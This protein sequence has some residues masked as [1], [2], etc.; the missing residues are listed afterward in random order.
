MNVLADPFKQLVERKLWPI[1]LL[2]V[3]ALVAVPVLLT[4]KADDGGALPT[5]STSVPAGQSPTEPVVS[6]A[7]AAKADSLRAVLGDRKDPFRPAQVHHVPKAEDPLTQGA[8][9]ATTVDTGVSTGGGSTTGGT[10]VGGGDVV[11]TPD[12]TPVPTPAPET[13]ELY[14]LQV[15]F[16]STDGELVS[17][18][19]KR[20]TGLPGGTNPAVLYLGLLDD[21]KT[22]VFLVD[23]GVNVLGDGECD[24]SPDNCQTLTLKKGETEFLTRGDQQWELDLVDINVKKTDD[25]DVAR[26]ARVAEARNGRKVARRMGAGKSAY[27]YSAKTGALRHLAKAARH[28]AAV[29]RSHAFRL[30][31]SG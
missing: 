21:H 4:K 26:R 25:A 19:V 9:T 12:V 7:D 27:R 5:A 14:S 18:N 30:D 28:H 31:N 16:G 1:A 3:A 23:A 22:A 24:P 11:T 20:L 17:R 13:F 15:R 2:L 29:P 6:V 8:G 10:T